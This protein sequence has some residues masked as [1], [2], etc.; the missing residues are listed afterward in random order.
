[1][2]DAVSAA[3]FDGGLAC[4]IKLSMLLIYQIILNPA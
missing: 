1:M 4:R 3:I 2:M